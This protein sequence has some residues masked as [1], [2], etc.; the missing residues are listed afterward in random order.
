VGRTGFCFKLA[1]IGRESVVLLQDSTYQ[2]YSRVIL[3]STLVLDVVLIVHVVDLLLCVVLGLL[4][5]DE[6]HSLGL[7]KLI[8][9]CACNTGEKLLCELVGDWLAW[10]VP[11]QL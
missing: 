11:C 6:V 1:S 8:D 7:S 5:V 3:I 9:F 4:T 10:I 2:L